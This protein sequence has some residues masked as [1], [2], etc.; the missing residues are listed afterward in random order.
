MDHTRVHDSNTN[1]FK[2]FTM[3]QDVEVTQPIHIYSWTP[4]LVTIP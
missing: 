1:I 4:L 3:P 2:Y